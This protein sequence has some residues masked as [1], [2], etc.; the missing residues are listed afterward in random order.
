MKRVS[1]VSILLAVA[2]FTACAPTPSGPAPGSPVG[3]GAVPGVTPTSAPTTP[4][5]PVAPTTAV[6]VRVYFDL[7]EKMQPVDRYAS[8]GSPAVLKAALTELLAG[9][10]AAESAA[11]LH[12]LIPKGTKLNGV[13]IAGTVATVDLSSQFASGGGSLSMTNRLAQVVYTATQF[14][15]VSGVRFELDG[16]PVTVFGGE[17]IILD[18]PQTRAD[19][20]GATPAILVDRP[21][22]NG[23]LVEGNVAMGTANVFEAVFRMQLRDAAGKLLLDTS[24]RATSGTGTRG[25]WSQKLTWG[26]AKAGLGSLKVFAVSPKDG[27]PV[28]VLTVPVM[29]TP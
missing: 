29:I 7:A 16:K 9:P 27:K 17:G 25:T 15:G 12:T 1:I 14:S 4:S 5:A 21:A 3:G 19:F 20:E 28:D 10:D 24:V 23:A 18:H 13:S 11:G 8:A 22:W 2:L 6:S 26:T